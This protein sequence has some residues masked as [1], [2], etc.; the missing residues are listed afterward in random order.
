[1]LPG[2]PQD[3]DVRSKGGRDIS[4]KAKQPPTKL[5]AKANLV[6]FQKLFLLRLDETVVRLNS[7]NALSVSNMDSS[8]S[9]EESRNGSTLLLEEEESLVKADLSEPPFPSGHSIEHVSRHGLATGICVMLC[10]DADQMRG[11]SA[12]SASFRE[13][14]EDEEARAKAGNEE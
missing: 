10:M 6:R 13:R 14:C 7:A 8:L 1:V 11:D 12:S 9:A 4:K 2:L 5:P 3:S